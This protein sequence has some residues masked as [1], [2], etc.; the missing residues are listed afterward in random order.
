M[1]ITLKKK[2]VTRTIQT[3]FFS[4]MILP[5][6]NSTARAQETL[7][8]AQ[9]SVFNSVYHYSPMAIISRRFLTDG[10]YRFKLTTQELRIDHAARSGDEV[11]KPRACYWGLRYTQP[12]GSNLFSSRFDIPLVSSNEIGRSW[13]PA[14]VGDYSIFLSQRPEKSTSLQFVA[15]LRF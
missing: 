8:V 15:E 3:L 10:V 4:V 11:R 2:H 5:A 1:K 7:Q 12:V 6:T 14:A 13:A 9:P